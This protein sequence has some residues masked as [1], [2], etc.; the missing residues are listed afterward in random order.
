MVIVRSSPRIGW[1]F[2]TYRVV[3][4]FGIT[5]IIRDKIG[6][7]RIRLRVPPYFIE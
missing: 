2:G 6:I 1:G 3:A 7:Q 5:K 4:G